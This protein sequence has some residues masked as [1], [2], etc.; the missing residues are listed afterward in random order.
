MFD[1]GNVIFVKG[2]KEGFG[3]FRFN[4]SFLIVKQLVV[5]FLCNQLFFFNVSPHP[6]HTTLKK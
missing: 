2:K 3:E 4:P 5:Q 1:C 6:F